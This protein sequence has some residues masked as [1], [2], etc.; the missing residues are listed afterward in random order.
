MKTSAKKRES[1]KERAKKC[2]YSTEKW[3]IGARMREVRGSCTLE[4][5]VDK[6]SKV[7]YKL[8]PSTISK[9]ESGSTRIPSDLL[10]VLAKKFD[11]D[12]NYILTGNDR[13][14]PD[15]DPN[16]DTMLRKELEALSRKYPPIN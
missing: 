14:N 2:G 3:G 1:I 8:E 7:N 11:C 10:Y 13:S 4:E 12:I 16:P 9:Y 5:F 6:L 15:T